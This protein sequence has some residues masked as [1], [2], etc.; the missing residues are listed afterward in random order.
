MGVFGVFDGF[1]LEQLN[2]REGAEFG[3]GY[4][5]VR[6]RR[7]CKPIPKGGCSPKDRKKSVE[8]RAR[9]GPDK[10]SLPCFQ[11]RKRTPNVLCSG[12]PMWIVELSLR[13]H[14]PAGTYRPSKE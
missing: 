10:N 5:Q 6:F 13:L 14:Y 12:S 9:N 3:V 7:V 1:F 4:S 2:F 8:P 11:G